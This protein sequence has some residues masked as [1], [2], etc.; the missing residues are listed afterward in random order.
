MRRLYSCLLVLLLLIPAPAWGSSGA[1][2]MELIVCRE[3]NFTTLVDFPCT[4]RYEEN[5][6]LYIYTVQDGAMPYVLV[7]VFTGG[8]RPADGQAYIDDVLLPRYRK[9]FSPNGE[10]T[11][12]PCGSRTVGGRTVAAVDV[13]YFNKNGVKI[14]LFTAVD[15]RGDCTVLY[16]ARYP[17]NDSWRADLLAALDTVAANLQLGTTRT[18]AAPTGGTISCAD[19]KFGATGE[20]VRALQRALAAQGYLTGTYTEG[21]LDMAT[22]VAVAAFC[23]AKGLPV[24]TDGTATAE[25]QQALFEETGVSAPPVTPATEG[26]VYTL[27]VTD[28]VDNSN[29]FARCVT[30]RGYAVTWEAQR[31]T[32]AQSYSNPWQL[33]LRADSGDGIV[34]DYISGMDF[35][36]AV[37][38]ETPD[39]QFNAA[40]YTPMLH[41]MNAS[42]YCDFYAQSYLSAMALPVTDLA[43]VDE[44]AFPA[45]QGWLRGLAQAELA[46]G[47]WET[48]FSAIQVDGT[49][50]TM[51]GRRY[52]LQMGGEV[53]Y[54][55]VI[56]GTVGVQYT[57][58]YEGL[59][60]DKRGGLVFGTISNSWIAWNIP[61]IY[62]LFC[63]ADRWAEADAAFSVFLANTSESD[64]F[65]AANRRLSEVLW[66]IVAGTPDLSAGRSRSEQVMREEISSGDDYDE[67][68][69]TDYLF[70]QNDYTLSDGS[71]VKVSTEYDYVYEGD[72][73]VV[74]YSSSAFAQPG[75]ST[76]LYPNR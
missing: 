47:R 26:T 75:G 61:G 38:E 68:R 42:Q 44:D 6:G 76:Q 30:P 19:L 65:K 11:V 62:T 7:D 63:P 24:P 25:M 29:A 67:E 4:T 48:Q 34:M 15:V 41:Y 36:S 69:F 37:G 2:N 50:Y 9:T 53:W 59:K 45:L 39:G 3:L 46:R 20:A 72:G 66:D 60:V 70:D 21:T 27:S 40:Y 51:C 31:C 33:A 35:L 22:A 64:Q 32:A 58:S 1:E 56:T 16:R 5:V 52:S 17:E 71:H 49:E 73:G 12:S 8:D 13:T 74:Y 43:L 10:M 55:A 18:R 23:A 28:L 14:F 57:A 54:F